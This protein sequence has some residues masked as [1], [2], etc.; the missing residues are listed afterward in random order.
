[1]WRSF[2]FKEKHMTLT[3]PVKVAVLAASAL[4]AGASWAQMPDG[5]KGARP[6][7]E[8]PMLGFERLHKQLNLN[9]QQ[10]ELWRKAQTAQRDA[11]KAMRA[12][13][14]ETRA[15]LRVEIDKPGADLKQFSQLGDRL[16]EEMRGEME[17]TRKQTRTAW[18]AV[19]DS[20]DAKQKEQVRVAI[21]DGMD[22][23]AHRGGRRGGP[24]GEMHGER[25][26]QGPAAEDRS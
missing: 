19:Y 23:T 22:R 11:F 15:K 21:R 18:F 2:H 17:A 20:L 14:E 4:F 1:M 24:H 12:K 25:Y 6:E 5:P 8:G 16:R 10:E 13:G 9:P 26:E 3:R 7:R